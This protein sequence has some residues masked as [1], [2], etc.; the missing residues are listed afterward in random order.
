MEIKDM[1]AFYAIVEE[2]NISHAAIR[3]NVAQPALSRQ[4]KRLETS[5]GIKLFERGSRRIR[6][7]DA[8]M[9]LYSRVKHILGMVDGTMREL[10]DIGTGVAGTIKLGTITSS[11]AMLIPELVAEY[12]KKY[13]MVTFQVWEGD[14]A[15][16]LEL[17]DSHIVEIAITRTQVDNASYES[18]ILPDEPLVL[19]MHTSFCEGSEDDEYIHITELADKPLI[20]PL[21]WRTS[22]MNHCQKE[23][24]EPN[25]LSVSDSQIQNMLWTQRGIGISL[26]PLSAR[27]L[28]Q[29]KDIV[30]KHLREAEIYTHTVVSWLKNRTMSSS[31]QHFIKMFREKYVK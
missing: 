24:F 9:L 5:L 7:T 20:V 13:P 26:V 23:N 11:G 12:T 31:S 10:V 30:F 3:L 28:M 8:G 19:A 15:R 27:S 1:Q 25:I 14:G 4:M 18:I 29:S 6:L 2:G 17:L 16:V 22:F 21:R